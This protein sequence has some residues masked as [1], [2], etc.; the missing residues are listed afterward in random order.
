M[1]EEDYLAILKSSGKLSS[2]ESSKNDGTGG[3]SDSS[4][5]S[6]K[7][8][9]MEYYDILGVSSGATSSEIKKAYYLKAKQ[10]HPDR[11]PNDPDAQAKF[12]KIGHAYQILSDEKLRSNYDAGG[13]SGVEGAAKVDSSTL[14]AM[15]FGS[16]KFVPLVG[17][18]KLAT[19]MQ[20]AEGSAEEGGSKMRQ[21]KQKKREV[22][23]ATNLVVKLQP[24]LDCEENAEQYILT[25][26]EEVKE[27]SSSP[28][29]STLLGTIGLAYQEAASSELDT[30]TGF[31][32]S[33]T[34]ATRY[35]GSGLSIASEGIR[36]AYTASEVN[37]AAKSQAKIAAAAESKES[38][39]TGGAAPSADSKEAGAAEAKKA[40]TL[41]PEEEAAMQL[42]IEKLS[43]HM[44]SVMWM[45]T[46]LDIRG[47]LGKVCYRVLHDHSVDDATRLKRCK[48]ML[49]LGKLFLAHAGST[50]AGLGD[51]KARLTQQ[52]GGK[53]AD[54]AGAAAEAE[55]YAHA[56]ADEKE[57]HQ[58]Y[59]SSN[60]NDS[61]QQSNYSDANLD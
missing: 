16:E 38:A 13:A 15:I 12:Q 49:I 59:S 36:A 51:I 37:S 40:S 35:I 26:I 45:V 6:K 52:M 17:E 8:A 34:Q 55:A 18:L 48:A 28:F 20:S 9:D 29:G 19:Q 1:S 39:A 30:L 43:G 27:L 2:G 47:T 4:R 60:N 44:F 7:V 5:P 11:H 22:Q 10:N 57:S 33:F 58:Q 61:K 41:S 25:Q 24:Y 23:C 32:V 54:P 14:F 46:E 3:S 31:A 42:K 50:A 21:F 53:G 56:A